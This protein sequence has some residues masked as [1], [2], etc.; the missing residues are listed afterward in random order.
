MIAIESIRLS[1]SGGKDSFMALAEI[2]DNRTHLV[3]GLLSTIT[4]GFER[5]SMHG[6]RV[7]LLEQQAGGA[8][9]AA[10]TRLH[11]PR[12]H[13]RGVRI[14]YGRGAQAFSARDNRDGLP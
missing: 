6:V 12:C 8:R 7:A 1:W 9:A 14:P 2:S 10:A 11:P 5:V 4:E 3:A 13:E